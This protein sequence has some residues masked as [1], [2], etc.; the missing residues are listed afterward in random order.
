MKL[1]PR[2]PF[3]VS[4]PTIEPDPQSEI[5]RLRIQLAEV[6]SSARCAFLALRGTLQT[7]GNINDE[8]RTCLA[9]LR[10]MHTARGTRALAAEEVSIAD[11]ECGDR[12]IDV[13]AIGGGG[14]ITGYEV[15]TNHNDWLKEK[16][17]FAKSETARLYCDRW[18]LVVDRLNVIS[19]KYW[20]EDVPREWGLLLMRPD[21]T[22]QWMREPVEVRARK[23]ISALAWARGLQNAGGS[24]YAIAELRDIED[25]ANEALAALRIEQKKFAKTEDVVRAF[26]SASGDLGPLDAER[27]ALIGEAV[28]FVLHGGLTN[29]KQALERLRVSAQ[30]VTS[31]LEQI[32]AL[33]Q[34][35]SVTP[36]ATIVSTTEPG[37]T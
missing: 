17:N 4:S 3:A 33:E 28:R 32:C 25:R 37:C 16:K 29:Q 14:R 11:P 19:E 12:V 35:L 24:A 15:K 21:A 7:R 10:L 8:T 36:A 2:R 27:T 5:D 31:Y 26:Q 13:V 34:L 18:V 20:D 30:G 23:G 9:G 1:P 22:F 6:Q